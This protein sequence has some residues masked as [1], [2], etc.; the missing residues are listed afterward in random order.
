MR[1]GGMA[2]LKHGEHIEGDAATRRH[3]M[4]VSSEPATTESFKSCR[5]R[6]GSSLHQCRQQQAKFGRIM[7]SANTGGEEVGG[8]DLALILASL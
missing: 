3:S 1:R 6:F 5:G 8:D 4:R 7:A 2:F